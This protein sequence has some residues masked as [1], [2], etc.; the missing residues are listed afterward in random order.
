MTDPLP[1]DGKKISRYSVLEKL[2]GGGMGVVYKAEGI[3][4]RTPPYPHRTI[5]LSPAAFPV[6][7]PCPDPSTSFRQPVPLW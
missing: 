1:L 2:G 3:V 4:A 5:C 6:P 7:N